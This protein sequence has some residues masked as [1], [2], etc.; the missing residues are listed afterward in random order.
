MDRVIV[1]PK[2]NVL[3]DLTR[4]LGH[5]F[6]IAW[7]TVNRSVNILKLTRAVIAIFPLT[8]ILKHIDVGIGPVGDTVTTFINKKA[9]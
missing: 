7:Q 9:D 1:Q 6:Q 5:N 8:V 4:S 3:S 2:H